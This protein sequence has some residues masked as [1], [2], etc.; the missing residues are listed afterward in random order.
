MKT[1]LQ[2]A[3]LV[4]GDVDEKECDLHPEIG[5][6]PPPAPPSARSMTSSY[7]CYDEDQDHIHPHYGQL[8]T[9]AGTPDDV[10]YSTQ[11]WRDNLRLQS[12]SDSELGGQSFLSSLPTTTCSDSSLSTA[13]TSVLDSCSN[14]EDQ[15]GT[16]TMLR[17]TIESLTAQLEQKDSLIIKLKAMLGD[18]EE[19]S[20][21][22][23]KLTKQ[24][25][26]EV[27]HKHT[28]SLK[29]GSD[30]HLHRSRAHGHYHVTTPTSSPSSSGHYHV[31]TPTSSP[32]GSGVLVYRDCR[33]QPVSY[34]SLN[35][36]RNGTP[37]PSVSTV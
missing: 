22:E 20:S 3:Q 4:S 26:S 31:T 17:S 34:N 14:T 23:K 11:Q 37:I 32:S 10:A 18:R 9:Y 6:L 24:S 7:D 28:Q 12:I 2:H 29:L 8:P 36:S 15:S 27:E 13:T 30:Q 35:Y 21:E 16:I 25:C 19:N 33:G 5:L 1:S